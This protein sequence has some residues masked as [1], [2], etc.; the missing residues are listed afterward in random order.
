MADDIVTGLAETAE[1]QSTPLEM[2]QAF[3]QT[4]SPK[5]SSCQMVR[6]LNPSAQWMVVVHRDAP[7]HTHF[8]TPSRSCHME[9]SMPKPKIVARWSWSSVASVLSGLC[10]YRQGSRVQAAAAVA[11]HSQEVNGWILLMFSCRFL[12]NRLKGGGKSAR[13]PRVAAWSSLRGVEA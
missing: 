2:K 9:R 8:G 7:F 12:Q 3:S 11:S 6:D 4:F 10:W 5:F 1:F 13:L